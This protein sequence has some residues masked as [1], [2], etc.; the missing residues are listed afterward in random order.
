MARAYTFLVCSTTKVE[1]QQQWKWMLMRSH[2][3]QVWTSDW[4]P[5][6]PRR[7]CRKLREQEQRVLF[8]AGSSLGHYLPARPLK[9]A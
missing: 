4:G 6:S 5:R 2:Q 1:L 7:D 8:L 3:Q 9:L